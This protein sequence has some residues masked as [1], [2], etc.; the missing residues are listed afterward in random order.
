MEKKARR[1]LHKNAV[2]NHKQ[3]LDARPQKTAAVRPFTTHHKKTIQ[4]RGT[5]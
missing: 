2:T 5:R 1:Q 3:V 4:V